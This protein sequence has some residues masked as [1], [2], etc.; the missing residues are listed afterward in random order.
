MRSPFIGRLVLR[1]AHLFWNK[2][3]AASWMSATGSSN[4]VLRKLDCR[5][6]GWRAN[7]PNDLSAEDVRG[8]RSGRKRSWR[9]AAFAT[10]GTQ[11]CAP[12]GPAVAQG[13]LAGRGLRAS[14]FPLPSRSLAATR[15]RPCGRLP[16]DPSR[17]FRSSRHV[18]AC[19]QSGQEAVRLPR[20]TRRN[21]RAAL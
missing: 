2:S 7:G 11:P 10:A 16:C 4:V 21:I 19:W 14:H 20:F 17:P 9:P 13:S 12:P 1:N 3:Q 8:R 18:R 6:V 5:A 15:R